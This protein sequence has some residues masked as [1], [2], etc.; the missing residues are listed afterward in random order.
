MFSRLKMHD[1]SIVKLYIESDSNSSILMNGNPELL[2]SCFRR[3]CPVKMSG[4]GSL[5]FWLEARSKSRSFRVLASP[6][7]E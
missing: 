4:N 5:S 7:R 3:C 6:R 1:Y 2:F